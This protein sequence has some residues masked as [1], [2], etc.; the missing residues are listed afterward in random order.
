MAATL[1][2]AALDARLVLSTMRRPAVQTTAF[3][4][5][6][7]ELDRREGDGIVVSLLWDKQTDATAIALYDER[8]ADQIT[9]EVPAGRALDAFHHPYVYADQLDLLAAPEPREP[10]YA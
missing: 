7:L 10:V 8:S 5:N 4:S 2:A 9:F 1:A 6:A 3:I